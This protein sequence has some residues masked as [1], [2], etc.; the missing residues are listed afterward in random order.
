MNTYKLYAKVIT[1]A[2]HFSRHHNISVRQRAAAS[3]RAENQCSDSH[4]S[5]IT[6]PRKD[7]L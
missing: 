7:S 2:F 1:H 5:H 4:I 6:E 3:L